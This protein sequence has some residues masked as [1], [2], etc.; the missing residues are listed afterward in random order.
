MVCEEGMVE[1][2]QWVRRLVGKGEEH[3]WGRRLH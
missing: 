1:A 3:P 2:G